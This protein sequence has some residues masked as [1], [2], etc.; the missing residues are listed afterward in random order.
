MP[1]FQIRAGD[2]LPVIGATITDGKP[3]PGFP[4]GTPVVLTGAT[5]RFLMRP[6]DHSTPTLDNA[7]TITDPT[8]GKVT[9]AWAAGDT[10]IAGSYIAEWQIT[11]SDGRRLTVPNGTPITV[12]SHPG[13]SGSTAIAAGD[14]SAIRAH[15]GHKSPP[16]DS[17][18]AEALAR[19]GSVDAVALE[20]LESRYVEMI[21]GPAKWA[22]EGDFNLD[23]TESIK[24]LGAKVGELRADL[25]TGPALTVSSIT[26]ADRVGR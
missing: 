2:R 12:E 16:T 5:V 4:N 19:L 11:F 24:R 3:V 22:V 10:A 9:Y 21:S 13:V 20:V 15:I 18:L 17:E 8:G 25:R 23:N 7:A 14:L 6:L 1:D 26:R